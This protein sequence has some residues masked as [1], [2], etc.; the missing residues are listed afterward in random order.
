MVARL[1]QRLKSTFF[2]IF[3]MKNLFKKTLILAF[4]LIVQPR[5][6]HFLTFSKVQKTHYGGKSETKIMKIAHSAASVRILKTFYEYDLTPNRQPP[7]LHRI[8]K[9]QSLL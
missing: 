6:T 7:D 3:S 8:P 9:G 5:K 1:L 2:E 4:E